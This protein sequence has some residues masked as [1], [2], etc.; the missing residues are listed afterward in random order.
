MARCPFPCSRSWGRGFACASTRGCSTWGRNDPPHEDRQEHAEPRPLLHRLPKA[1]EGRAG[2]RE[3]LTAPSPPA[4]RVAPGPDRR[5]RI[6]HSHLS[7]GMA[8]GGREG[9]GSKDEPNPLG[10]ACPRE[11][12]QLQHCP[13]EAAQ[14]GSRCHLPISVPIRMYKL[15]AT[16]PRW[17]QGLQPRT[18]AVCEQE[19][20][21]GSKRQ[22]WLMATRA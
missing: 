4:G 2:R 1:P 7:L 10:S 9:D 19:G 20:P 13:G 18:R 8:A 3:A 11:L 5:T 14:L 6:S 15:P 21:A 17:H 22:Q 12:Q 16:C